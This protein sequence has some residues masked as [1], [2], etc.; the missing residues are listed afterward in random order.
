MLALAAPRAEAQP[1]PTQPRRPTVS[2]EDWKSGYNGL[3][4]L[5]RLNGIHVHDSVSSW[6]AVPTSRSLMI[7]L[8]N[9]RRS[10]PNLMQYVND[11][12]ALLLATDRGNFTFLPWGVAV[13]R[14]PVQVDPSVGFRGF[15]DCPLADVLAEDDADY[16]GRH[17]MRSGWQR[18]ATNRSGTIDVAP[19][20]PD[21]KLTPFA[22][23]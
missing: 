16:P 12:G 18:L 4:M 11:G 2:T 8:G 22:R 13:R 21:R 6:Q 1:R 15:A 9:S 17:W 3:A 10:L 5:C 19:L 20:A 14:G 23:F 7:V